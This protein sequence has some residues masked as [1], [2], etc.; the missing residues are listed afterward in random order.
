MG[1]ELIHHQHAVLCFRGVPINERLDAAG[2]IEPRP[3]VANQH[4]L[5]T[6]Q[7]LRHEEEIGHD[8]PYL[9][10]IVSA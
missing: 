2:N 6:P 10:G 1:I 5:A 9:F 4:L 8:V 3:L 7:W